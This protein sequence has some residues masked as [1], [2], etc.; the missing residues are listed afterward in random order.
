VKQKWR[1]Q[2]DEYRAKGS[3]MSGMRHSW[4]SHNTKGHVPPPSEYDTPHYLPNTEVD[5]I[6]IGSWFHLEMMDD[7]EYW[8]SI[9]GLVVNVTIRKDGTAKLVRYEVEAPQEGVTYV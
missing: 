6:V 1:F 4:R 2:V 3:E 9:G 7:N 5:E 8:M